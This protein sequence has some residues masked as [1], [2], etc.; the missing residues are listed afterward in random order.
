MIVKRSQ[1][2]V[3]TKLGGQLSE[4]HFHV[5]AGGGRAKVLKYGPHPRS[6]R[7]HLHMGGVNITSRVM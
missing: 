1:V 3:I 2:N 5:N 6:V 7:T 4:L